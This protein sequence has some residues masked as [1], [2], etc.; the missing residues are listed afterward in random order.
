M[1]KFQF[2]RVKVFVVR[3]TESMDNYHHL[4][5]GQRDVP[6]TQLGIEQAED[7][8]LKLKYEKINLAFVS[9]LRRTKKCLDIVLAYHKQVEV[10][11]D[12]RIMERDYGWLS[13]QSKA[14]W[15][16]YAYPLFKI[17]HR[18]YVI[19]P[20]GGESLKQMQV[21]VKEFTKDMYEIIKDRKQN[22]IICAHSGSLR[23]LR[24]YF[25]KFPD[26]EFNK[27]ESNLGEVFEYY[28]EV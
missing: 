25:E 28:L 21:R 8:A 2:M 26:S 18:S 7:L 15:S 16:K 23:G 1:V 22:T 20:P 9:P 5:S 3:H 24:Q 19:P 13:G 6:L 12:H 4:F 17:F 14:K 27:I 11:E 10:I